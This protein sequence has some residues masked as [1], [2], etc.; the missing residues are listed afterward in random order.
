MS[1]NTLTKTGDIADHLETRRPWNA[2]APQAEWAAARF[3]KVLLFKQ[4]IQI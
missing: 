1:L 2:A 4:N 3:D